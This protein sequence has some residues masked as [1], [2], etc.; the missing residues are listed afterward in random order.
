MTRQAEIDW[1]ARHGE[2]V[3]ACKEMNMKA[4]G[5]TRDMAVPR[6]VL[7]GWRAKGTRKV[8][9]RVSA[10]SP[11]LTP[12]TDSDVNGDVLSPCRRLCNLDE[13]TPRE[14]ALALQTLR[15]PSVA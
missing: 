9:Q 5:P 1:A 15:D 11:L 4:V 6:L 3:D 2:R 13:L 7:R 14:T 12:S 10:A 8:Q